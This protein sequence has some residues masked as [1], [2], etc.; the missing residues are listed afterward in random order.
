MA[1][2]RNTP[3]LERVAV[4]H[5][6]VTAGV[7]SWF[8]GGGSRAATLTLTGVGGLALFIALAALWDRWRFP[9][10]R[11]RMLR[12]YVPFLA[13]NLLICVGAL[14]PNLRSLTI[15]GA[16]VL[17]PRAHLSFLPSSATP[18]LSLVALALFDALYLT[19]ANLVWCVESRTVLTRLWV[20]FLGNAGILAIF[21][22]F[23][24]LTHS[25][26]IYFGRIASP[27]KTFF[28][29]FIYHNHWGAFIV[30]MLA[31]GL[32]LAFHDKSTR[33]YRDFWHSPRLLCALAAL[34]CA[35]TLPLSSSRS[36]TVLGVVCLGIAVV[37][38]L[39]RS[40]HSTNGESPLR[41]RATIIV[42]VV[43]A[44]GAAAYLLARPVIAE[45]IEDTRTQLGDMQAKGTI[46]ARAQL[47]RDTWNMASDQLVFGWGLGSYGSV[48]AR[49]NTLTS[50]DRLPQHYEDAHS[51]WLQSLAETGLVGSG[52]RVL[53]LVVPLA[54]LR[55]AHR[56]A[57]FP[58]YLFFG[59]GLI[60][61]Y[62]WVE[63][64][65]GNPAVTLFFGLSFFTAVRYV[66]LDA[67]DA[68]P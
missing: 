22:T 64:P 48:F 12:W 44:V 41:I 66:Q 15:E 23:Q 31:A 50:P 27:N 34:L 30:V 14:N 35:A 53:L 1:E 49:Y 4:V 58:A 29:T 52:L 17:V 54:S 37:Q 68:R 59:C 11:S 67:R 32:G 13:F 26:G 45:R 20:L 9:E 28:A 2:A 60:L 8:L 51:D 19:C 42:S 40:L 38:S 57:A 21:G 65:F 36:C 47:Y 46:G 10:R 62:A 5:A 6:G 55:R 33:F 18:A 7:A 3:L 56:I 25:P 43:V 39:R 63:F 24:K 61:L 16:A